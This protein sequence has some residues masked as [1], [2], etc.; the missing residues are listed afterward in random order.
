MF[1]RME[2]LM[3]LGLWSLA[4][5]V[6]SA[7]SLQPNVNGD[8]AMRADVSQL[9]GSQSTDSRSVN[10]RL[11]VELFLS[12]LAQRL[13]RVRFDFEPAN[14]G[15][16]PRTAAGMEVV[17]PFWVSLV[18]LVS[19]A[20]LIALVAIFYEHEKQFPPEVKAE[21][22]RAK[23]AEDRFQFGLLSCFD[24][25]KTC[26]L[27]LCCS[28]IRWADT[29]RMM[30]FMSFPSALCLFLGLTVLDALTSSAGLV[31]LVVC[32]YYRQKIREKFGL[33]VGTCSS[34][35]QDCCTFLWCSCCAVVQEARQVEEAY[36]TQHAAVTS[37][38]S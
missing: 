20:S 22:H 33:P 21:E 37:T 9:R 6:S 1:A 26:F 11:G 4:L 15:R 25:K 18:G 30:G 5:P 24:D 19:Y 35:T 36:Q 34:I 10:R 14:Q 38:A 23:L 29:V 28:P 27:V 16:G 17:I 7:L 13:R 3:V 32:T 2:I 31:L 8:E 12:D